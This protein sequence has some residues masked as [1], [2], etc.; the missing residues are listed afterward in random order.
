MGRASIR[1]WLPLD[2]WARHVGIN[3]LY[4][5]QAYSTIVKEDLRDG[6]VWF[7]ESWQD[8]DK[9]SR[10]DLAL[11]ISVAEKKISEEVGYHLVPDWIRDEYVALTPPADRTLVHNTPYNV[12]GHLKSAVLRKKHFR[13]GG[14]RA[15][16][17]VELNAPVTYSDPDGD[18]YNE[19][20]RC[21]LLGTDVD[22]CEV[23]AYFISE[24]A[25]DAWEIRPIKVTDL[26]GGTLQIDIEAWLLIDPDL[27]TGI[28]A[29]NING[30][31]VASYVRTVDFYRIYNDAS[32]MGSMVWEALPGDACCNSCAAC[33]L[34]TQTMCM[35]SRNRELSIVTYYPSTW[36]ANSES[37]LA[38]DFSACRMPER[39]RANYYSG[40]M[41]GDDLCVFPSMDPY[42]ERAIVLLSFS[43]MNR[44]I[45]TAQNNAA[46]FF[47][48]W[49]EDLARSGAEVSYNLGPET[50]RNPFG[51]SRGAI[52]AWKMTQAEGR[53]IDA[54]VGLYG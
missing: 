52:E 30:D 46:H 44:R 49:R 31:V 38:A 33:T 13:S 42:W 23:H 20:G 24:N 8:T 36:D 40:W 15:K 19:L 41:W 43:L 3:P 17:V 16:E 9:I 4:F 50:L 48:F 47:D 27:Q 37:H 21:T 22:P 10:E 11:A 39:L 29:E 1:T 54:G 53:K 35:A 28:G 5:N 2:R 34:G 7:Q 26:G 25:D 32:D 12:S 6:T 18:G 45:C 51:T 14:I